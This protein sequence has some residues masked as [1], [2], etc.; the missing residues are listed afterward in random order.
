[1]A[2]TAPR[3]ARSDQTARGAGDHLARRL[4]TAQGSLRLS[5]KL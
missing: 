3:R 1:M 5:Q 4:G 2:N